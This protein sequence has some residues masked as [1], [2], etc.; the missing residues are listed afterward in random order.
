MNGAVITFG[1][2]S[3][4]RGDVEAVQ[5]GGPKPRLLLAL[6]V[7][8]ANTVFP[9]EQLIDALWDG[10]PPR[11][12][13]KNLQVY[14]SRLRQVFADR[15]TH[16]QGGYL[17]RIDAG[18]CDLVRFEKLA[19][20]GRRLARDGD[21][22]AAVGV[23]D[24][25]VALWRGR[26]LA[27]L[28][29]LPCLAETVDRLEELFLATLE[30]WAELMSER[31]AHRLVRERVE[32][33]AA[34]HPLRERL[35]A[36]WIRSLAAGG[37]SG[38]GLAHFETV[39]TALARELG[40]EP[41][42]ELTELRSRLAS[43]GGG[44]AGGGGGRAPGVG[45]QLPR[46]LPD[47]VG[48]SAES[49]LALAYLGQSGG[50]GGGRGASA[51]GRVMVVSGPVGV[52]KTAFAVHVAHLLADA[53]PDG[54]LLVELG[55]RPLGTVLH[56]LLDAVG[57]PP[58]RT[59]A[60]ALAR[61]RAWLSGRRLLLVLDDV[62]SA[63][64]AEA[65]LPGSGRSAALVTSRYR[66]SGLPGVARVE[67]SPFDDAEGAE[68]LG[69]VIGFGRLLSDAEAGTRIVR[70]C[71][72]LPLAVRIAAVKLDALRHLRPAEYADRLSRAPSLLDE[73]TAGEL[74]LRDRYEALWRDLHPRQRDACRRVAARTPPY[75]YGQVAA[76]AEE[77]LECGLLTP[78][79]GEVSAHVAVYGMSAFA[80]EFAREF[81]GRPAG[82]GGAERRGTPVS[83]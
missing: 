59:V 58:E 36:A 44:G 22:E 14:V 26:P 25:A 24:E 75:L 38:E 55:T 54:L 79:G 30:E 81:A 71:E 18:E 12:A 31:G 65:L 73:M 4:R 7:S 48:R 39:R 8:R 68:L 61:W 5:L 21:T 74:V 28:G 66:L 76:D 52:G 62:V 82:E 35:A 57:L 23:L 41:G 51:G 2:L 1:G 37:R 80:R 32:E 69:R 29:R 63:T 43:P 34:A 3:V 11:T 10:R 64:A 47:F 16:S 77:L 19:R 72:G 17:L 40:V 70:S 15:L 67:L 46:E 53:F 6:L 9:A 42:P 13:R 49:H 56:G 78:P 27:E 83:A 60:Q 33:H 20:A 45:N 50:T